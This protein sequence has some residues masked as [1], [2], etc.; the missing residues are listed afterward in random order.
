MKTQIHESHRKQFN[1]LRRKI[2][3]ILQKSDKLFDDMAKELGLVKDSDLY[4][5]IWDHVFNGSD[6]AIEFTDNEDHKLI[7]HARKM[8]ARKRTRQ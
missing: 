5:N 8:P 3:L 2:L 4:T 1:N 7:R 6:C